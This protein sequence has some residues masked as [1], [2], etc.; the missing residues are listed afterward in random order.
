MLKAVCLQ[1]KNVA[2]YN[3]AVFSWTRIPNIQQSIAGK[4]YM[5][6]RSDFVNSVHT[7]LSLQYTR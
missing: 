5:I 1:H 7:F 4:L 3:L 6:L 2:N